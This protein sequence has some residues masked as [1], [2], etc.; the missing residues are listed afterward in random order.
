MIETEF[1][2]VTWLRAFKVW[3]SLFW[4]WMLLWFFSTA[5]SGAFLM[6]FMNLAGVSPDIS[7]A[8]AIFIAFIY[9]FACGIIVVKAVLRCTYSDFKITLSIKNHPH[10]D[11]GLE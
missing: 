4:R 10:T 6:L 7:R 5:L 2:Q 3:W 9:A 8:I 1:V 11:T